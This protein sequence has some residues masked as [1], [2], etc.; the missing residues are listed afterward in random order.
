[1]PRAHLRHSPAETIIAN[2][3]NQQIGDNQIG[4]RQNGFRL[5]KVGTDTFQ[6]AIQLR[7]A[8]LALPKII[9]IDVNSVHPAQI[10]LDCM[11]KPIA[12]G[13]AQHHCRPIAA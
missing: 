6:Y 2:I 13:Y 3:L 9:R 1:M 4:M 10:A 5:R 8:I 7:I 11:L 12:A